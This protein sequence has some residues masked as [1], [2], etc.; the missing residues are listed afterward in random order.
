[1]EVT[2]YTT[3]AVLPTPQILSSREDQRQLRFTIANIDTSI[4]NGLRRLILNDVPCVVIRSTPH[5]SNQIHFI[6]NTTRHTNEILKQRISSVPIHIKDL[7]TPIQQLVLEVNKQND[8]DAIQYVTTDDFMIINEETDTQID[9]NEIRNIFPHDPV[10]NDPILVARLRPKIREDGNG[11]HLHFRAKFS[12]GSGKESGMFLQASTCAYGMTVNEERQAEEWDR[13]ANRIQREAEE[14]GVSLTE[15]QLDF[16][17]QNWYLGNGKRITLPDHFDFTIET[18]GVFSNHELVR[19]ACQ[20]MFTKLDTLQR[21]IR[22]Q[23]I[24]IKKSNT[25]LNHGFDIILENED[26]TLGK[27]IEYSLYKM[28]YEGRK[29]KTMSYVGFQK[30]HPHDSHSI[31]R[32]GFKEQTEV[33]SVLQHL[34]EA[35]T[36]ARNIYGVI[37]DSV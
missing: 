32:I 27:V 20:S 22:E 35:S 18:I 19:L 13:E 8:S 4:A 34:M 12:I 7:T 10:T 28:F 29:E 36:E 9:K 31:I 26:Y 30:E 33:S 3:P 24:P 2:G 14:Q 1:M 25:T 17:R 37:H 5:E 15:Q 11:E 21:N 6:T 16:E 23:T